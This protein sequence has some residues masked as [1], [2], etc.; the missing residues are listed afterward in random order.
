MAHDWMIAQLDAM[1]AYAASN[2]LPALAQA[3]CDAKLLALTE[4]ASLNTRAPRA[5]KARH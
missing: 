5:P 1:V 2:D 3:L 4:I